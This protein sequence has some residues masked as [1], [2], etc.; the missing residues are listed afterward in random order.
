MPA[1]CA[2]G[3]AVSAELVDGQ[4]EQLRVQP[5]VELT[6]LLGAGGGPHWRGT[7]FELYRALMGRRTPD[8]IAAMDWTGDPAP[9]LPALSLLP[10]TREP[11]TV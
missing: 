5:S 7:A 2:P 3:A 10:A 8:Q 6:E 4:S 11:L 9:V 1:D